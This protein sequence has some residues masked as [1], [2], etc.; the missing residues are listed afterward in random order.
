MYSFVTINIIDGETDAIKFATANIESVT[1]KYN[2]RGG[3]LLII[4]TH[5]DTYTL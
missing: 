3:K 5:S 2:E 4:K 1:K